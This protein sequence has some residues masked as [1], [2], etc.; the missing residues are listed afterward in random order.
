MTM[1]NAIKEATKWMKKNMYKEVLLYQDIETKEWD[2]RI[3]MEN[4]WIT[5]TRYN[6]RVKY[7]GIEKTTKELKENIKNKIEQTIYLQT[8]N[9]K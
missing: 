5:E 8:Y 3:N 4:S 7:N 2:W 6:T 1:N 9:E